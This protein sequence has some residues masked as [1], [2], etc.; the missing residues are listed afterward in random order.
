MNRGR[1]ILAPII[2][3]LLGIVMMSQSTVDV[4][5]NPIPSVPAFM[6]NEYITI[7]IEKV[8]NKEAHVVVDGVYPMKLAEVNSYLYFPIPKEALKGSIAVSVNGNNTDYE[9]VWNGTILNQNFKYETIMGT[10]PMIAWKVPFSGEAT[11]RVT[12]SYT[13]HVTGDFTCTSFKTIYAMGTGRYYMT[14]AKECTAHVNIWVKGFKGYK[15]TL[16]MISESTM[17]A[18]YTLITAT[19]R[20]SEEKYYLERNAMFGGLREDLIIELGKC[21]SKDADPQSIELESFEL[22]GGYLRGTLRVILPYLNYNAELIGVENTDK[23]INV[24][25]SVTKPEGVVCL[26]AIKEETI[27]FVT[28]HK[29]NDINGTVLNVFVN[30]KL[31]TT[32]SLNMKNNAESNNPEQNNST[33]NESNDEIPLIIESLFAMLMTAVVAGIVAFTVRSR[34]H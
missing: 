31:Y 6:E 15:L 16:K 18:P 19:V 17:L 8:N 5:A 4:K 2:V 13:I 32:L 23:S 20:D 3:L 33:S 24:Y 11:I 1:I 25:L 28:P 12:Y 10:L 34:R 29:V 22:L 27:E 14:Y 7:V 26:P 21:G 9:I 30:G